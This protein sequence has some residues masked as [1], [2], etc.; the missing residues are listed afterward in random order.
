MCGIFAVHGLDKTST[1][2]AHFI[3][4]SKRLRHRGPDWSG[5]YVGQ[6]SILVH[7]RLAIVG[8]G[9]LPFKYLRYIYVHIIVTD[10]GAQPLV[11]VDGKIIL[12]VNGEIYN[13]IALRAS[14][15]PGVK[16][17]TNSDCEVIM[18][19]VIYLSYI[20]FVFS[21]IVRSIKNTIKKHATSWTECFPLFF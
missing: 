18:S 12:T 6:N 4:L 5:C 17:Q 19:L 15:G 3:A 8:V 21:I 1:Y 16:F 2:R 10:T 13:H 9:Q 7:E 14:V 11:S 20:R